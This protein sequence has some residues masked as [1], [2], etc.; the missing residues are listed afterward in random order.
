MKW[1]REWRKKECEVEMEAGVNAEMRRN[2][3]RR[4]WKEGGKGGIGNG[5]ERKELGRKGGIGNKDEREEL[6]RGMKGR[7]WEESEEREELG[8][9]RKGRNW[10]EREETE[11]LEIRRKG[12]NWK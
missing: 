3:K 11:E 9:R 7:N 6:G 5:D 4:N 2:G 12:R 10:E 8:I 1:K